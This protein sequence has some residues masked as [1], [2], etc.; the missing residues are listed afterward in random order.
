[1]KTPF[2]LGL[3][4]KRGL[5]VESYN[6][7]S[8]VDALVAFKPDSLC[9]VGLHLPL[10]SAIFRPNLF[11]TSWIAPPTCLASV[12]LLPS[13]GLVL[14]DLYICGSVQLLLPPKYLWAMIFLLFFSKCGQ[15]NHQ[16]LIFHIA[17]YLQI[18]GPYQYL[19]MG[20]CPHE[21]LCPD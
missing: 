9:P 15:N 6:K 17:L 5:W 12:T 1:M 4:W 19:Q 2:E 3:H 11:L 13:V 14:L 7:H 8:P 18:L 16:K 20:R 21:I 10:G